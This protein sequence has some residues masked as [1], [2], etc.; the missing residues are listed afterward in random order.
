MTYLV[1]IIT[2]NRSRRTFPVSAHTTVRTSHI[3]LRK[4]S[5]PQQR[6]RDVKIVSVLCR[7]VIRN[8]LAGKFAERFQRYL[9]FIS[10]F[11]QAR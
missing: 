9:L 8:G 1:T 7:Y 10:F 5:V 4:T 3:W 11:T 2:A 6:H